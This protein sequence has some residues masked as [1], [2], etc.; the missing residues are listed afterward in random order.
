MQLLVGQSVVAFVREHI[1]VSWSV[2]QLHGDAFGGELEVLNLLVGHRLE[3]VAFLRI[4]TLRAV[5][6]HVRAK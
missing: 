2:T 6:S 5:L 1:Y 4:R 3:V